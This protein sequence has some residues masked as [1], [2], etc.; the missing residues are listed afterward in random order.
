MSEDLN[1]D[2]A[3]LERHRQLFNIGLPPLPSTLTTGRQA[4]MTTLREALRHLHTILNKRLNATQMLEAEKEARDWLA[5]I[6]SE[7][8]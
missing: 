4:G 8:P 6:G 5:S 7:P 3:R 1:S 2:E